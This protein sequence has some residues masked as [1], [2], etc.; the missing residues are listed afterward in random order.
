[1]DA[2][3]VR[4]GRVLSAQRMLTSLAAGF[5]A[6]A[7]VAVVIAPEVAVL[8]AWT[9]A[10]TVLLAWV[11]RICWGRDAAGTKQVAEE[12]NRSRSTDVWVLLA[13]MASLGAWWWA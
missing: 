11:W 6:G 2:R 13:A 1:V 7:A 10:C 8:A 4:S 9:V 3:T 5:L 12:E